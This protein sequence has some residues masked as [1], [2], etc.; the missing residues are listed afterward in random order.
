[1]GEWSASR[2]SRLTPR[3][4]N[5]RHPLTRS[6]CVPQS[7]SGRFGDEIN[8]V[9]VPAIEPQFLG[10]PAR[11]LG[12]CTD[13]IIPV[14]Y[15]CGEFESTAVSFGCLEWQY[16]CSYKTL[17]KSASWYESYCGGQILDENRQVGL[18]IYTFGCR[19]TS[20][21]LSE[22]INCKMFKECLSPW[23]LCCCLKPDILY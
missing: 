4:R 19:K 15:N 12:H 9:P 2:P 11:T 21:F 22:V 6:L 8:I 3:W 23:S 13:N 18:N 20:E 7:R 17:W 14:F 1:M 16:G 10:R 5:A